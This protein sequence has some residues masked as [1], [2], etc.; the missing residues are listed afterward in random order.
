[1]ELFR[2]AK[3]TLLP[4]CAPVH[5]LFELGRIHGSLHQHRFEA[6]RAVRELLLELGQVSRARHGHGF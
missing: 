2:R 5:F 6:F 3:R 4:L 1:M